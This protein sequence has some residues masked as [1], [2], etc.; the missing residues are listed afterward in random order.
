M[1]SP[2]ESGEVGVGRADYDSR[3]RRC[4]AI[5]K[6][7]EMASV[8]G[9]Q[10]AAFGTRKSQ[11]LMIR[12]CGVGPSRVVRRENIMPQPSQFHYDRKDDIFVGVKPRHKKC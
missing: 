3:V 2:R 1:D 6:L 4:A 8:V 12:H 7:K 11:Y 10:N 5:M 9:K